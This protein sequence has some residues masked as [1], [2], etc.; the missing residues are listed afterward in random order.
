MQVSIVLAHP[1]PQS[2]NHAIAQAAADELTRQKQQVVLHDL[3]AEKFDPI[4]PAGEIPKG[5]FVP[6]RVD[7]H[8]REIAQADGIS[9][10]IP[11]GGANRPPF[12]KAGSIG[13]F[14]PVWLINSWKAIK[15]TGFQTAY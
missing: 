14:V 13:S 5:A 15:V 6:P 11:I 2:F 12:S 10:S 7:V 9:S 8:C 4:L 3:Y 1:D